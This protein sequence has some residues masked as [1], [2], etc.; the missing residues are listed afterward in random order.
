MQAVPDNSTRALCELGSSPSRVAAPIMPSR[1]TNAI[2]IAC[3][4][5]QVWMDTSP[6]SGK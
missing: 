6:L 4:S 1:P 3:L 2:S 5:A